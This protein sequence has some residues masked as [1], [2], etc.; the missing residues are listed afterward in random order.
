MPR[1]SCTLGVWLSRCEDVL[2]RALSLGSPAPGERPELELRYRR[3]LPAA[4]LDAVAACIP[5]DCD[6]G[7][8]PSTS[9]VGFSDADDR[10]CVHHAGSR[11]F[12]WERKCC[13]S[14][15]DSRIARLALS[16]ERP[17]PA[18]LHVERFARRR[19]RRRWSTAQRDR[20]FRLDA[21][22]CE[23]DGGPP[24]LT[25]ELEYVGRDLRADFDA[26]LQ[27]CVHFACVCESI[28]TSSSKFARLGPALPLLRSHESKALPR[29]PRPPPVSLTREV[30]EG[31]RGA[32]LSSKLDG[33]QATLGV[34]LTPGKVPVATLVLDRARE[35]YRLPCFAC[36]PSV[37]HGELMPCG[38]RF[39][40]YD[41]T[42][43]AGER[44]AGLPLKERL[45]KLHE[46]PAPRL[47]PLRV[48]YKLFET[49]RVPPEAADADGVMVHAEDRDYKWK[50]LHTVDLEVRK[51]GKL[52]ASGDPQ[53]L[54]RAPEGLPPGVWECTADAEL[55]PLRKRFDK[56][57]GNPRHVCDEI[58]RAQAQGIRREELLR[59]A[60]S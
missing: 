36:R 47:W 33:V 53:P 48:E 10:R 17:C 58:M 46:Q 43:L 13:L 52:R 30:L 16:S 8:P 9:C 25:L 45:R 5:Y 3:R 29:P 57:R 18:P 26:V 28:P 59:A 31:L 4:W 24:E 49:D 2:R 14:V 51:D 41:A 32:L 54:G 12:Y 23:T 56:P 27:A 20:P 6:V 7:G 55:R 40:A 11:D 39:V 37:L 1:D 19:A 60:R 34:S 35:T 22:L 42:E 21:T 44:V 38:R 15:A 50:P